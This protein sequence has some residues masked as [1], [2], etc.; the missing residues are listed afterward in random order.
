MLN[1]YNLSDKEFARLSRD[2]LQKITGRKLYL[3]D[4]PG[5][6]GVD[7]ADDRLHPHIAGQAKH[8]AGTRTDQLM[9]LLRLEAQKIAQIR[10]D[11][12]YLFLTKELPSRRL[13]EILEIFEPYTSLSQENIFTLRVLDDLLQTPEYEDI[14]RGYPVLWDFSTQVLHKLLNGS[15]SFDTGELLEKA[16]DYTQAFVPTALYAQCVAALEESRIVCIQGN[17]GTGKSATSEMAALDFILRGYRLFYSS[18]N[19]IS[20]LKTALQA[21]DAKELLLL[22][23]F[24]G[25]LT[26]E[27]DPREIRQLLSLLRHIRRNDNKCVILNSRITILQETYRRFPELEHFFSQIPVLDSAGLTGCEKARILKNHLEMN[28]RERKDILSYLAQD[29]RSLS[30]VRHRNYNPRLIQQLTRPAPQEPPAVFYSRFL[31]SLEHPKDIWKNE[32]EETLKPVDRAFL[33]TLYSLTNTQAE[34]SVLQECLDARL[35]AM[36]DMDTT[37]NHFENVLARLHRSMVHLA[38][39]EKR[40]IRAANPSVNDFLADYLENNRLER[41]EIARCALYLDQLLKIGG[42][43]WLRPLSPEIAALLEEKVRDRSILDMRCLRDDSELVNILLWFSVAEGLQLD[44]DYAARITAAIKRGY[45]PL[46]APFRMDSC[47]ECLPPLLREP[48]YSHYQMDSLLQDPEFLDGL[49]RCADGDIA[50]YIAVTNDVWKVMGERGI[51]GGS[52]DYFRRQALTQFEITA[53]N[54]C[55]EPDEYAERIYDRTAY[56]AEFP[57]TFACEEDLV[58]FCE[59]D[60]YY[61]LQEDIRAGYAVYLEEWIREGYDA[62][63]YVGDFAYQ[64][65]E[66]ALLIDREFDFGPAIK[67]VV[68][69]VL[70]ENLSEAAYDQYWGQRRE[71]SYAMDIE[72]ELYQPADGENHHIQEMFSGWR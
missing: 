35:R 65:D 69:D 22:D 30:I 38:V 9:R 31:L 19:H 11:C 71:A 51:P 66:E 72:R 20:S 45:L 34:A 14:L 28:C 64:A 63:S 32:F 41:E 70:R 24:L 47:E 59:F 56:R 25:Q 23:D 60:L 54:H 26:Y 44:A 7:F 53:L 40:M 39:G 3:T 13:Q 55:I 62:L 15:V 48:L 4:M 10:P 52:R 43:G 18:D 33:T 37:V 68:D 67:G 8:A 16:K 46:S 1:F 49:I 29:Q 27:A 17:P 21:D 57:D 2:I 5:D 58:D 36:P 12:Y 61:F 6:R 42:G 50:S